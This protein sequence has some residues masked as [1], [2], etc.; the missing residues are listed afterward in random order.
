M[1]TEEIWVGENDVR[2]KL[3]GD[4][5]TEFLESRARAQKAKDDAEALEVQ[6]A[7]EKAALLERLG[8]TEDE[9]KLLLG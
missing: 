2:R 8:I 3:E 6:R 4:E 9:A 1:K 7:I 5:L